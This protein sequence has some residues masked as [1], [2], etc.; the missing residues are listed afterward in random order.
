M[1]PASVTLRDGRPDDAAAIV[2]LVR[3]GFSAELVEAFIYGC[4]GIERYVRGLIDERARGV[5]TWYA[6]AEAAGRVVGCIEMREL[7]DRLCLNYVAVDEAFRAAHLGSQLLELAVCRGRPEQRFLTLDVLEQNVVARRWYTGLGMADESSTTWYTCAIDA[8]RGEAEGAAP[9]R[10]IGLPQARI[11]QRELGFSLFH[12][13]CGATTHA[14]GM[15]GDRWFRVTST[16]AL[17]DATLAAALHRLDPRRELLALIP[18][19]AVPPPGARRLAATLRL[20]APL[21][22]VVMR[23]ARSSERP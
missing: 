23:L 14:V 9:A 13:A 7:A 11:V 2:A 15:L 16:D 19:D 6:V 1:E 10:V 4:H 21:G 22:D 17:T 8:R 18:A 20:T 12:V 5:D 3:A